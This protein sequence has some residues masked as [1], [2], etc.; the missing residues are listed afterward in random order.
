MSD[1]IPPPCKVN[2]P[3]DY[4]YSLVISIIVSILIASII[5]L[6]FLYS[7]EKNYGMELLT[8]NINLITPITQTNEYTDL[9]K[10]MLSNKLWTG[11]QLNV[12]RILL[13]KYINHPNLEIV[14]SV[15]DYKTMGLLLIFGGND[16]L[17]K[18]LLDSV[19]Y[20]PAQYS[21]AQYSPAS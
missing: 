17:T 2:E 15:D 1:T 19:Q 16:Q 18:E 4:T 12:L 8:K 6:Y 21:P 9:M 14:I 20:S 3:C 7:E 5:Y 11:Y 10:T 13:R